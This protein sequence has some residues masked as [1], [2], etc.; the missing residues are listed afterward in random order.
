MVLKE[1]HCQ[2]EGKVEDRSMNNN[3]PLQMVRHWKALYVYQYI[4]LEKHLMHTLGLY[5]VLGLIEIN[6]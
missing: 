6:E 3:C 4:N 5:L 2:K 1:T